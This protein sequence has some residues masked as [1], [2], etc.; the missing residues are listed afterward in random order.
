MR[1]HRPVL[2]F[3]LVISLLASLPGCSRFEPRPPAEPDFGSYDLNA[4]LDLLKAAKAAEQA[5]DQ[6]AA[7]GLYDQSLGYWP[8]TYDAWAGLKRTAAD[9]DMVTFANFFETRIRRYDSLHPRQARMAYFTLSEKPNPD[10]RINQAAERMVAFYEFKDD[11]E[12][13]AFYEAQ[14]TSWLTRVWIYPVALFSMVAVA[15]VVLQPYDKAE[16]LPI[17]D[18]YK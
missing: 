12:Q 17:S 15:S 18:L 11:V 6:A 4:A 9:P 2:S 5:G 1:T 14:E 16:I 8:V 13:K 7:Q 10:E 3:L